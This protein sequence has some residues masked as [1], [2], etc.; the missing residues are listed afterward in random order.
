VCAIARVAGAGLVNLKFAQQLLR[1]REDLLALVGERWRASSIAPLRLETHRPDQSPA[2]NRRGQ[3]RGIAIE[4]IGQL[5]E[6][7]SLFE[8]RVRLESAARDGIHIP[9]Y[10][11]SG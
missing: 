8:K 10:G 9:A 6:T 2:A 4:A 7:A 1:D 5:V 11:L 3:G